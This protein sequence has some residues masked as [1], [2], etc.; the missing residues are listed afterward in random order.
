LRRGAN[1]LGVHCRQ[2]TG[3]QY[4]DV[5]LLTGPEP[6]DIATLIRGHGA[7]VL[8]AAEVAQ[9]QNLV[10]RLDRSRKTKPVETGLE[11]MCVTQTGAVP[12]HVLIRGNPGAKGEPV[13]AGFPEVLSDP[14]AKGPSIPAE[15]GRLA[16]ADWLTDARNPLTAR[17]MANRLWQY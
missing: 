14:Q 6:P 16:L 5:G 3:G 8:G 1:V 11:V 12:T 10:S 15:K 4:I 9:Y 7:E 13:T 2:T 17:V